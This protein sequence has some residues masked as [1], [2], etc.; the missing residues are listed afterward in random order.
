[1]EKVFKHLLCIIKLG[2]HVERD[3]PRLKKASSAKEKKVQIIIGKRRHLQL[4]RRKEVSYNIRYIGKVPVRIVMDTEF[5]KVH[6][7]DSLVDL[8]DKLRGEE[9]SAVVLDEEGKLL[10]FVT[11]KDL[12]KFFAPFQKHTVI[13]VGL[14]KRYSLTRA[15]RVEDIMI[16]KPITI[17]IEDT[18][19]Q[20]I[21]IMMET[22]KHHLPVIDREKRVHGVLEVKDIIRLIRI[23]SV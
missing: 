22:G 14:L 3:I 17:G 4:E 18:L 13:G 7:Q 15:S 5:L 12:L 8:I 20:A 19:D 11:M 21:K 2:I 9:T 16:T 1:M 6:P 23:V 10:G